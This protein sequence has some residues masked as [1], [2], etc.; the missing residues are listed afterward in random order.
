MVEHDFGIRKGAGEVG[1][2][3]DLGMKQPGVEA[4]AQRRQAGKTFAKRRIEQ[5]PFR[6]RRIHA[7]D[8]WV[9]VPG[10]R[11][12]NPAEAAVAG[13]D[14]RLQ[15]GF[16]AVAEQEIDVADDAGADRGLAVPAARGH[17]RDAVGEFDL[18]DRTERL[19]STRAVHRA[20]IDIDGRD[21]VVARRDVGR[22]LLDHVAQPATIPEMVMRVD[23]RTLGI[24]DFFRVL[25]KPVFAWIGVEPALRGGCSAGHEFLSLIFLVFCHCERSEAIRR[26]VQRKNGLLRCARNDD[27]SL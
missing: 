4:E 24:D 23:D 18:A 5:Q 8:V 21:D 6:P 20:A 12:P 19:R 15:H 26:A 16:R 10:G 7:G 27:V 17:R 11:M 2:F 3:A 14:L 9:R 22:H 1:G 13:C 25:R